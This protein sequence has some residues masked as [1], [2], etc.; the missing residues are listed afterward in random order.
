MKKILA[1]CAISLLSTAAMAAD[2]GPACTE[3]FKQI[4]QVVTASPQGEAMK[5]QYDEAKKQM[6]SMP[7]ATQEAA[8]KQ[9]SKQASDMM[10]QAMANMP[11]K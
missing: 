6:A 7:S 3:Y 10:K 9:A 5:A 2:V 11:S 1:V 4:D 8:C